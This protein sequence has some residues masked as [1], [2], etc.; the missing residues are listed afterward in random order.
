MKI[1]NC[2]LLS[3]ISICLIVACDVTESSE[4]LQEEQEQQMIEQKFESQNRLHR[5]QQ[6]VPFKASFFTDIVINPEEPNDPEASGPLKGGCTEEPFT[7]FN[8]QEGSGQATH[9][10]KLSTRITFCVDTADLQDDGTLTGDESAPYN[11]GEGTFIAANG[12]ELYFTIEGVVLP[13][14]HPEYNFEF[15]DPF[16]FT[17]GTGRFAGASGGG[18]TDSLVDQS[19]DRTEHIWTGKILFDNGNKQNLSHKSIKWGKNR[20]N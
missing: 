1:R 15:Q 5:N 14:D 17:G 2:L 12:D 20:K 8:V 10:G 7:F 9:L 16:I 19:T 6:S 11:N 4:V 3:V 13:S 18:W